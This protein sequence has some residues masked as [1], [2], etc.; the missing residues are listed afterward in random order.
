MIF[1]ALAALYI[2][3]SCGVS[4]AS[5]GMGLTSAAF[6]RRLGYASA[7]VARGF[8]SVQ[9]ADS[10]RSESNSVLEYNSSIMLVLGDTEKHELKSV[11]VA[12]TIG[13]AEPRPLYMRGGPPD[14]E[15][16]YE[17]ICKQ[18]IFALNDDMSDSGATE[19][20]EKIGLY[21][22]LLDG[23]QRS[24]KIKGFSYMMKLHPNGMVVMAVSHIY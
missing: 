11:A 21:G 24:C 18:V 7:R 20:L 10:R 15:T 6:L 17:N 4:S 22:P 14:N 3:I 8:S 16:I 5:E 23:A 1:A 12:Y 13:S 19:I 9:I 2:F